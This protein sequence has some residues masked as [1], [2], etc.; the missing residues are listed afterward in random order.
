MYPTLTFGEG[1]DMISIY[2][3]V[4]KEVSVELKDYEYLVRGKLVGID[5]IH[6]TIEEGEKDET[7]M[8]SIPI[9]N[10]VRIMWDGGGNDEY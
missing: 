7:L 8:S 5:N 3:M 4:G 1:N 2:D 10:T 6:Y 9:Q